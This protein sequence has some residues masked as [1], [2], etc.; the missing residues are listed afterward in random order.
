[1]KVD[2]NLN[3]TFHF[4]SSLFALVSFHLYITSHRTMDARS[5]LRAKKAEGRIE[6]PHATYT[7]AGQLRCSI[8]AIPGT[9][10]CYPIHPLQRLMCSQTMGCPS[11]YETAPS[12]RYEREAITN[13]YEIKETGGGYW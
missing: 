3:L 4:L 9:P 10:F 12:I 13:L 6:H 2:L 11:P 7:A 5:L 1:M 8:C